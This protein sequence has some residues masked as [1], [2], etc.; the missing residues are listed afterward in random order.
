MEYEAKQ[1]LELPVLDY[2]KLE[3]HLMETRPNVRP[4]AFVTDLVQRW[5]ALDTERLELSRNGPPLRG[6]Q[7]KSLFLPDG[8]KL[9]TTYCDATEFA[10][11][12]SDHIISDDDRRLTPSQFANRHAKGRNAWRFV[13][14]RFPGDDYWTR[15]DDCR[16]R[17]NNHVR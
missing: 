1:S 10:K 17:H 6:V 11:V 12:A 8:T 2:L 14:I 4:D 16:R 7:W 15:A 9:R 3:L 5:L 13:W